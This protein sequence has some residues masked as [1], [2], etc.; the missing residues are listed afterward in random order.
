MPQPNLVTISCEKPNFKRQR[1]L[2]YSTV[3]TP[4][5]IAPEVFNQQGYTEAVDWWSVGIILFEMLVGYPPFY[6]DDPSITCQKIMHWKQT[7]KIPPESGVSPAAADLILRLLRDRN[8][9]FGNAGVGEIKSH[10]FF[11]GVTW[12]NI[13]NT[14]APYIPEISSEIDTRNFENFKEIEPFY[15]ENITRGSKKDIEFIGYTFKKEESRDLVVSA[16]LE[17]ET[18]RRSEDSLKLASW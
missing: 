11:N 4:D 10:P 15:P 12:E 14:Q 5:Y 18:L 3:G 9:R 13:R 6:S 1:H 17:L 7:L 2:A 16:L 8:D